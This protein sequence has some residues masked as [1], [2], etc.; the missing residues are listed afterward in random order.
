MLTRMSR[1]QRAEL[2]AL[3]E[4]ETTMPDNAV[5]MR[6]GQ[7]ATDQEM[8]AVIPPLVIG[9]LAFAGTKVLFVRLS[10]QDGIVT[11]HHQLGDQEAV[12]ARVSSAGLQRE[13]IVRVT[14]RDLTANDV[15]PELGRFQAADGITAELHKLLFGVLSSLT[16]TPRQPRWRAVHRLGI[17]PP[18]PTR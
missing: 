6:L 18:V 3:C 1:R 11:A 16:A 4:Q 2:R 9:G 8:W 13:L 12:L 14:G 10:R 7:W 5:M 15:G 17:A